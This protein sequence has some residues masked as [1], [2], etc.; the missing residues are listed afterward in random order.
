VITPIL[1][2]ASFSWWMPFSSRSFGPWDSFSFLLSVFLVILPNCRP[3]LYRRTC[4]APL[5][6]PF[7]ISTPFRPWASIFHPDHPPS[8]LPLWQSRRRF[9]FSLVNFLVAGAISFFFRTFPRPI[10]LFVIL[11]AGSILR[12]DTHP[13]SPP[14][15][16]S[17]FR[18]SFFLSKVRIPSRLF[19]PIVTRFFLKQ[20][21]SPPFSKR[22]VFKLFWIF[23]CLVFATT[24]VFFPLGPLF[25]FL[26]FVFWQLLYPSRK[27]EDPS[28]F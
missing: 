21:T 6:S 7:T 4:S 11:F 20:R 28:P 17:F 22:L 2:S 18:F 27:A 14:S 23:F 10:F 25:A 26:V 12:Y 8:S 9:A 13:S 1:F 16:L 24:P 5:V 19:A 3:P 15:V